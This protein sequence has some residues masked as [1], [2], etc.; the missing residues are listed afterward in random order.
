MIRGF[1]E[2]LFFGVST[3]IVKDNTREGHSLALVSGMSIYTCASL[4]LLLS[5]LSEAHIDSLGI[6][7]SRINVGHRGDLF[8]SRGNAR[9]HLLDDR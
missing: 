4:Q 1:A 7:V 5:Q 3:V 9:I 8:G 6:G 2:E